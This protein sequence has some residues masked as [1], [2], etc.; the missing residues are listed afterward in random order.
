MWGVQPTSSGHWYFLL[1]NVA[2]HLDFTFNC[3]TVYDHRE[4]VSPF[5]SNSIRSPW[6]DFDWLGRMPEPVYLGEMGCSDG[7]GL[8]QGQCHQT[9]WAKQAYMG[10]GG[11]ENFYADKHIHYRG[12]V[13]HHCIRSRVTLNMARITLIPPYLAIPLKKSNLIISL[14]TYQIP[15]KCI[16]LHFNPI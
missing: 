4:K 7:S 11:R 16:S 9:I 15:F 12:H 6:K 1:F 5:P 8:E 14:C 3:F 13:W 2:D 10:V